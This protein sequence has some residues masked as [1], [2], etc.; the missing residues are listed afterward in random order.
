MN[1]LTMDDARQIEMVDRRTPTAGNELG[2]L[3]QI[4]GNLG[5][6]DAGKA[7]PKPQ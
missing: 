4:F 1:T 5:R 3:R 2:F 7:N 6:F